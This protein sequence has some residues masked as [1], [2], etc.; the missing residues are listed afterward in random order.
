MAEKRENEKLLVDWL[1]L[2][3][4]SQVLEICCTAQ[5]LQFTVLDCALQIFVKKGNL[6]L[7]AFTIFKIRK[8][9][10]ILMKIIRTLYI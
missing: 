2:G 1:H 5:R 8:Y 4:E 3:K 10:K 9:L 6:M 7:S